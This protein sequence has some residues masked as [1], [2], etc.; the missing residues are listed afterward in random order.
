MTLTQLRAGEVLLPKRAAETHKGDYGRLLILGGCRGYTGAPSLCARSAVRSGAGLV[1]LGVP[2]AI[3]DITAV[4]NDEAMPFPL[5][6]DE[7]G[8]FS[9]AAAEQ[10]DEKLRRC[11]VCAIGPGM[12]RSEGTGAL[13][14]HVL[15]NFH[16]PLVI[17]ATD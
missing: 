3:Y 17:D 15:E 13:L 10:L 16:G 9:A 6:S 4:K 5:P 8:M 2:S 1:Y 7:C 11:D 12:G 14:R